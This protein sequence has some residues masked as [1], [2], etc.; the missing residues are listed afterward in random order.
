VKN[1][2]QQRLQAVDPNEGPSWPQHAIGFG[3]KTVLLASGR[4]VVQHGE[5]DDGGIRAIKIWHCGCIAAVDANAGN[6]RTLRKGTCQ[7]PIHLE[8]CETVAAMPQ[9]VGRQTR[10]MSYFE[11]IASQFDALQ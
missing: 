10:A 6:R 9:P 11:N 8:A 2:H 1:R 5:Q 3:E 7:V 4:H